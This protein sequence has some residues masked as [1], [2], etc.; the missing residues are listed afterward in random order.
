MPGLLRP[1]A[2][3]ARYA[4][5]AFIALASAALADSLI[6]SSAALYIA[7]EPSLFLRE[8]GALVWPIGLAAMT[9]ALL[10]QPGR[11]RWMAAA[12][13]A[14]LL[15]L[16]FVALFLLLRRPLAAVLPPLGATLK[17][18]L[19][20]AC[21]A[22]AGLLAW[23]AEVA[24][25]WRVA[26]A[27][28]VTMLAMYALQPGMTGYLTHLLLPTTAVAQPA[29]P[30]SVPPPEP[31]AR[32]TLVVILDEWDQEVSLREGVFET[33]VL[34]DLLSQSFAASHAM[35]AG[36][37]TL[38]SVPSMMM[39]RRLGAIDSGGAGYLIASDG[40]R[41]D[42]S[43]PT[44]FTDLQ[45]HGHAYAV[46]GFYH[47]YCAVVPAPR[48]CHAEPVRFFP[49]W[50]ASL[51]R[52]FRQQRDFDNPYTDFL[53]Q[54]SGTYARLREAALS[55]VADPANT[56]VWLHLNVPHPP[57]AA[58]GVTP[59]TLI[60]DY[61]ANLAEMSRL[62]AD[63]R[64]TVQQAGPASAM[65]LTSDHWLREKE[66]WAAIYEQQRGPGAGAAGKTNDQHV[67]FIV[68]FSDATS[69]AKLDQPISTTAL[70][71]LVP[72]LVERRLQSPADVATFFRGRSGDPVTPF[73]T[74]SD[75]A[76]VH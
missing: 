8:A 52:A 50:Q 2:Q 17:A 37:S 42:A 29:G 44:L 4:T 58:P 1:A 62:L 72:A 12:A 66:M 76:A 73:K 74:R 13:R 40:S 24:S 35:P 27:S 16:L 22:L 41:F 9:G 48:R 25:Q 18:A 26:T 68:W 38:T 5:L 56:V 15:A 57:I 71:D 20:V 64:Q 67:P 36:T 30:P 3:A 60:E 21:L 28:A 59:R 61:R 6:Q 54:W 33:P 69:P 39:G 32:R 10:D 65:I 63:L 70:R 14:M 47:D 34:R 45:A 11:P 53:R 55:A 49:G 46:V 75:S 19:F 23:R 51:A 43:T 31:G 7:F